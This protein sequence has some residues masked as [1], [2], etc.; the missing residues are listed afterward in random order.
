MQKAKRLQVVL[1]NE[2]EG[3]AFICDARPVYNEARDDIDGMIPLT[4]M[5]IVYERQNGVTEEIEFVLTADELDDLITRAKKAQDDLKLLRRKT[6][7]WLPGG[8]VDGGE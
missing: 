3:I 8:C 1:G 2:V 6:A 5:K 4:T 7:E